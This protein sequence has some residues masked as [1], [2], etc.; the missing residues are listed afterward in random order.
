M[1]AHQPFPALPLLVGYIFR[2]TGL[3]L[4]L[5][6]LALLVSPALLPEV[7]ACMP[8]IPERLALLPR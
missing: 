7:R 3:Q 8:L 6:A 1:D 2:N 5:G 4:P